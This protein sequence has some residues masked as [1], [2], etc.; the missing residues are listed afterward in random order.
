MFAIEPIQP[1][2]IE[3]FDIWTK[4]GWSI[5]T[6]SFYKSA[7]VV[8]DTEITDISP[9]V[10]MLEKY[11]TKLDLQNPDGFEVFATFMNDYHTYNLYEMYDSAFVEFPADMR[12]KVKMDITDYWEENES[13]EGLGWIIDRS[14]LWIYGKLGV[15]EL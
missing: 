4:D 3:Y 14:E 1:K 12:K 8:I 7:K 15:Y 5:T 6:V 10:V 13:L 2:N 11:N 9:T